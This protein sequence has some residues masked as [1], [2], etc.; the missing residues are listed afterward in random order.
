VRDL[1]V[2]LT[3][4][5]P[6][7]DDQKHYR[8]GA[9]EVDKLLRRGAGWLADH[10]E[11]DLIT[12]RYL[13]HRRSPVQEALVRLV[14]EATVPGEDEDAPSAI[15]EAAEGKLGPYQQR[16]GAV[17]AVLR[18][19]GAQPVLDLDGGKGRLLQLRFAEPAL[20]ES[21]GLDASHR[22]LELPVSAS[23]R[24]TT[25]ASRA[26]RPTGCATPTTASSGRAPV[27]GMGRAG[28]RA[29]RL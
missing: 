15:P 3:V 16:L 9:D 29:G 19:S 25:R 11:R 23:T 20:E 1:F 14:E 24:S 4:L 7:L 10:P 26:C 12:R 28:G 13:R 5:I 6:V 22:A 18:A 27:P 8:V 17:L 2:P 21:A